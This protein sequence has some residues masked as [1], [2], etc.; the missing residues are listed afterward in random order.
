MDDKQASLET[1]PD[2]LEAPLKTQFYQNFLVFINNIIYS[3]YSR[4][5]ICIS[6][7][8]YTFIFDDTSVL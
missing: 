4:L 2:L 3:Y 7:M 6:T 8:V 1:R 5:I